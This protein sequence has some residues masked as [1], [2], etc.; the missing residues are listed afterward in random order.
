MNSNTS[1]I[2]GNYFDTTKSNDSPND[3]NKEEDDK[4]KNEL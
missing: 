4:E 2:F 3:I 1:N